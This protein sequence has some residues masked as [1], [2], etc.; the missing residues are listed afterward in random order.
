MKF[1]DLDGTI[2]ESRQIISQEMRAKL[3]SL[4]EPI[5]VISG[6]ERK[7]MEYQLN[8]LPCVILAQSGNDSPLWQNKLSKEEVQEVYRHL[9][10]IAKEFPQYID[11]YYEH[12]W[13]MDDL[14]ENR[15]CQIAFSFIGH[16]AQRTE[17]VT[18]DPTKKKRIAILKKVPF[19]SKTLKCTVAGTT[20]LDYTKKGGDKGSNLKRWI[21][22]NNLKKKDC[23]YFGDALFKGGNDESVIGVM[24][25]VEI[26]DPDDLLKKL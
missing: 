10:E 20:C 6:A 23:V 5:V 26:K 18:F 13:N 22:E 17:K 9:D 4:K 19:K 24:K 1:L 15:G 25:C 21:K 11:N 8:G 2:T 3:L 16:H 14:V 7:Q 12:F